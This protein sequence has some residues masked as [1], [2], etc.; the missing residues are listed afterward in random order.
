MT[1]TALVVRLSGEIDLA[2][3]DAALAKLVRVT[4]ALPPPDLAVLDLSAVSLLSAA[5][6]HAVRAFAAACADRGVRIHLVVA[7]RSISHRVVRMS[8]LEDR[9]PTFTQ[10]GLAL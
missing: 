4:A 6:V 5:A 9:L 8:G 7:P 2:S 1:S 3:A 10:L